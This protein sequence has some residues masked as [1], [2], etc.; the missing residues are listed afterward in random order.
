MLDNFHIVK[1]QEE[2]RHSKHHF[3]SLFSFYILVGVF[4]SLM[5]IA[6]D[7]EGFLFLIG[8]KWR[9]FNLDSKI[10]LSTELESLKPF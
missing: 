9:L 5:D 8:K 2:I 10:S 6:E 3:F 4:A 7:C 1:K